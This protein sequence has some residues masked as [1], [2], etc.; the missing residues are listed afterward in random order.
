M[1]DELRETFNDPAP[2]VAVP[3]PVPAPVPAVAVEAE[4]EDA[5]EQAEDIDEL[6]EQLAVH[7]IISEERHQEILEE[8][9]RCEEGLE[10]IRN[11]Q[12]SMNQTESPAAQATLTE[13][14]LL[15]E[16]MDRIEATLTQLAA[17]RGLPPSTPTPSPLNQ[18][19]E[20]SPAV[21]VAE[22]PAAPSVTRKRRPVL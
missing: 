19:V 5:E 22:V 20:S 7:Q 3:V 6:A 21:V 16:R 10:R 17:S 12:Q 4:V 15:R 9:G 2:V 1:A 13:L 18:P 14:T 11:Q 8:V